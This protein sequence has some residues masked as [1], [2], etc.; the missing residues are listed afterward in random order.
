MTR[1]KEPSREDIILERIGKKYEQKLRILFQEIKLRMKNLPEDENLP[2]NENPFLDENLL[3]D[4]NL[5]LVV[6]LIVEYKT[7]LW[8]MADEINSEYTLGDLPK[9]STLIPAYCWHCGKLYLK[10]T[11]ISKKSFND[12]YFGDSRI[13]KK[14]P[15][16]KYCS[17]EC[18]NQAFYLRK[19]K[20]PHEPGITRLCSVCQKPLPENASLKR[21]TCSD[22]CRKQKQRKTISA[23]SPSVVA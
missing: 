19:N 21:K 8:A 4:E 20:I 15:N 23:L 12:A 3:L 16:R 14:A 7:A 22:K 17:R 2:E 9:K 6:D 13:E 10:R 5:F 18:A 1:K 11:R